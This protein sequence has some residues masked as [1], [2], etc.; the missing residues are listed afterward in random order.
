MVPPG[1]LRG[2][3]LEL[4]G[5]GPRSW[6]P[7]GAVM[8]RS[9]AVLGASC[10]VLGALLGRLGAL[11]GASWAV[12]GW[13]RR[14]RGPSWSV[15]KPRRREGERLPT[16]ADIN[17]FASQGPLGGGSW[18]PLV[19]PQGASWA[20]SGP[21]WASWS[22][23]SWSRGRLWNAS[24]ASRGLRGPSRPPP[25]PDEVT[26]GF[27]A[28][29]V[30]QR[31]R[32]RARSVPRG[33]VVDIGYTRC[34]DLRRWWHERKPPAWMKPRGGD[35]QLAVV[36]RD[37]PSKE[38]ALASEALH[39]ARAIAAQP[40]QARGGPWVRPTL[41]A[42]ALAEARA[43][44]AVRVGASLARVAG[45]FQGGLL[46][47]HLKARARDSPWL[48]CKRRR[49]HYEGTR[50]VCVCVCVC[51][52]ACDLLIYQ[53]L[54]GPDVASSTKS[55]LRHRNELLCWG[56]DNQHLFRLSQNGCSARHLSKQR[57]KH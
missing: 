49:R 53:Y 10:A 17:H 42:G 37:L 29:G 13:P 5:R 6:A 2:G 8:G 45:E 35:F 50:G 54:T 38:A 27:W 16:T 46:W 24:G 34:L 52:R 44:S 51:V 22:A 15:G 32:G 21:S 26:R 9:W 33:A 14:L 23:R 47:K 3:R 19:A 7:L 18:R 11:L 48:P 4:S 25:G 31:A 12:L 57:G 39:A 20:V 1:A 43:A 56:V 55:Y 41:P 36:E 28:Q 40:G 30:R